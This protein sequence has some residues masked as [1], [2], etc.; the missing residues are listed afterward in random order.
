MGNKNT[1]IR[2]PVNKC[3]HPMGRASRSNAPKSRHPPEIMGF[4]CASLFTQPRGLAR[5]DQKT[6][7]SRSWPCR[8]LGPV[9]YSPG[10]FTG[11]AAGRTGGRSSGGTWG[12]AGRASRWF[13]TQ[14]QLPGPEKRSRLLQFKNTSRQRKTAASSAGRGPG[15]SAGSPR[16]PRYG[17]ASLSQPGHGGSSRAARPQ[18]KGF[19]RGKGFS[20]GQGALQLRS[21]ARLPAAM[22]PAPLQRC[23]GKEPAS[24]ALYGEKIKSFLERYK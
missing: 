9:G 6:W 19:S 7:M 23:G 2:R 1:G 11:R 22:L 8:E 20:L 12:R 17:Q 5:S 13:F 24:E 10:C 4:G 18:G 16:C 15:R 21:P 14:P 3:T